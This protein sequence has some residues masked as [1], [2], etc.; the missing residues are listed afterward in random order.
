MPAACPPAFFE[1]NIRT[2]SA[3]FRISQGKPLQK[4]VPQKMRIPLCASPRRRAAPGP[5]VLSGRATR[6]PS[7]SEPRGAG[8]KSSLA[9]KATLCRRH[10]FG[11]SGKRRSVS[12]H[13]FWREEICPAP[14]LRPLALAGAYRFGYVFGM[15]DNN[16]RRF[17]IWNGSPSHFEILP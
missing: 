10:H 4:N 12:L 2:D 13:F 3:E 15:E 5:V 1:K 7:P 17:L 11:I 6:V 9:W 8:Q 16:L 14:E